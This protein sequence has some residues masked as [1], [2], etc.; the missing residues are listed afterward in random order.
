MTSKKG[1]VR[2]CVKQSRGEEEEDE[3]GSGARDEEWYERERQTGLL[4][5]ACVCM[6]V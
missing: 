1:V 4:S 5:R 3:A 2:V 6:Y